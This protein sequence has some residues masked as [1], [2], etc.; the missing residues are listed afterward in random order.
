MLISYPIEY[1]RNNVSL[2]RD[3][4]NIFPWFSL[5]FTINNE[6]FGPTK[7]VTC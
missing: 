7:V 5:T 6:N 3:L 2:S 4:Q 1:M